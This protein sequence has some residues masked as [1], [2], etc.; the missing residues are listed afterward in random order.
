MTE[1]TSK[2][3]K[4]RDDLIQVEY[5]VYSYALDNHRRERA[6]NAE[7]VAAD[8]LQ[9]DSTT[10]LVTFSETVSVS[11]KDAVQIA[12]A[13]LISRVAPENVKGATPTNPPTWETITIGSQQ[14][15]VPSYVSATIGPELAG[16]PMF[17]RSWPKSGGM[18]Q[19][20]HIFARKD[21]EPQAA[22]FLSDL[23]ANALGPESPYRN[24]VVD[25]SIAMGGLTLRVVP[26]PTET[27]D[28]LVFPVQVWDAVV[29]NVDRMFERMGRLQAAGLGGNRGLLLAGPPGTGKTALCRALAR[30]YEGSA[31]VVIVSA[32]VGSHF[33]GQLYERL[34]T[35]APALVLVEDLDLIVGDREDGARAG[36]V[37]FLTVL[38]GLMTR[39]T[40][41]VTIATTN[42]PNA[43]DEAVTR[44]ARF[45]QVVGV[46]LPGPEAREAIFDLYLRQ[47]DHDANTAGLAEAT[48]RFSGADI[49]EVV[50]TAVLDTVNDRISQDELLV[51]VERR[52]RALEAG[53]GPHT[54]PHAGNL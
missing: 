24:R 43:I 50:R 42:D 1:E 52:R 53:P 2:E 6:K 48:H 36:L 22:K 46:P 49:R 4:T 13:N 27:R 12:L 10:D 3:R 35:L 29:R 45:D 11:D 30:E 21:D 40:G 38:D 41:V 17:L 16:F 26:T 31:T 14:L 19:Y 37:Q 18:V 15:Q 33:L 32:S 54:D 39:H 51:A 44:A 47:L 23:V 9:T 20:L 8:F 28:S 7:R 25:S 5:A 34:N